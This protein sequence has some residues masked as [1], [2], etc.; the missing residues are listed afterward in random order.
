M[1]LYKIDITPYSLFR[2]VPSSYTVFGGICWAYSILYGEKKLYQLLSQFENNTPPFILSSLL[3]RED[4]NYYFPKPNLKAERKENSTIDYKS[5]KKIQYV[6]LDTI[7]QVLDGKIHTEAELNQLLEQKLKNSIVKKIS[8]LSKE[9]LPHASI[10]RLFGTT[11]GTGTLFFD[12][13]VSIKESFLIVAVK[14]NEVK[15]ELESTIKLLQDIGLGGNRSIGFGR[16]KFGEFEEFPQLEK[17]FNQKTNRFLTLSPL[18]PEPLTYD[19]ENS[20]YDYF[21]FRGAI[22]N[23]YDFKNIDIWKEKVL[24]LKEGAVLKV[25]NQ[26]SFYGSFFTAKNINGTKIFQYGIAFP[27][28]IQGGMQWNLI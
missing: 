1:K 4:K 12:E 13:A 16:L 18:I 25:K 27:L 10:D 15:K 7:T 8:F 9:S 22:D 14:D 11:Q 3:P 6:D 19:L 17:Y 23:N 21:T 2:D 24:Y 28:Y 26:K 5:L 20:Y